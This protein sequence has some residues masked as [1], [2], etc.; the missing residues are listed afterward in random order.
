[1]S[2]YQISL[3]QKKKKHP[4]LSAANLT[5]FRE[6]LICVICGSLPSALSLLTFDRRKLTKLPTSPISPKELIL[7]EAN[8]LFAHTVI[9]L[10]QSSQLRPTISDFRRTDGAPSP[11]QDGSSRSNPPK[12][13]GFWYPI[14]LNQFS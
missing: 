9:I 7:R 5:S 4:R 14:C 11:V 12:P 10:I 2:Y 8:Q 6:T 3:S 1:M 13:E